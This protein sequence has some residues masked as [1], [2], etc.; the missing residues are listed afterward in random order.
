MA[1]KA[2]GGR[3][4]FVSPGGMPNLSGFQSSA[5]LFSDL[6]KAAYDIGLDE[7]KR[8]YNDLIRQAEIDGKTAGVVYDENNNLVPLTNFDYGEASKTFSPADQRNIL[9]AYKKAALRSYVSAAGSDAVDAAADALRESP[10]DPDKIRGSLAGQLSGLEELDPE[11]YAALAPKVTEAFAVAE[12]KAL[13]QQQLEAKEYAVATN[14]KA[15]SENANKLGV[16]AAKGDGG[17]EL[18]RSRIQANVDEIIEEQEQIFDALRTSG[19]YSEA[20]ILGLKDVQA[21]V[22]TAKAAVAQV[23]RSFAANGVSETYKLVNQIIVDAEADQDVD[24]SKVKALL[25][26]TM[27]GLIAIKN[28]ESD[29]E[30]Q[31]RSGVYN[32]LYKRIIVDGYDILQEFGNPDSDIHSLEG[33]QQATLMSVGS[34]SNSQNADAIKSGYKQQ[35]E[36]HLAVLGAPEQFDFSTTSE[37]MRKIEMLAAFRHIELKD[38]IKAK[39]EFNKAL[40]EFGSGDVQ[41]AGSVL[42][43]ELS[44]SSSFSNPPSYYQNEMFMSSLEDQGVIGKGG[45]YSTRKEYLNEVESYASKWSSRDDDMK[46]AMSAEQ[47][48]RNRIPA[49]QKEMSALKS[50]MGFDKVILS[51]G[52]LADFD[53][54]SQDE[55]IFT[56]SVDAVSA[57]EISTK[58][59]LHPDAKPIFDSAAMTPE[60]ADRAM[61]IMGQTMS[62]IRSANPAMDSWQH[63]GLFYSNFDEDT[64]G[65]LRIADR[66]GIENAL[67]AAS[68]ERSLNR[69]GS[70]VISE[71]YGDDLDGFFDSTWRE[72]LVSDKFFQFL[73]P[74]ISDED[75][76][77]LYAMANQAG[78]GDVEDMF[79]RD[80]YIREALKNKFMGKLMRFPQM[81]PKAAMYDTLREVG[82]RVGPEIDAFSGDLQFV[83]DPILKYAQSTVPGLTMADGSVKYD[84]SL[85]KEDIDSDIKD[86]YLNIPSIGNPFLQK[87]MASVGSGVL[88]DGRLPTPTLHYM[89]NE[90]YGGRP[91][92]TVVL[93]DSYGRAHVINEAYSYDFR[94]TAAFG[95]GL[96]TSSYTEALS[97]LNTD[98][99]KQFWSARGLMDQSLLNSTFRALERNRNDRSIGVLINAYNKVTGLI[100]GQPMSEDPL[101]KEEVDDFFYMIDRVTTLGWR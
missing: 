33:T 18:N 36:N 53:L 68:S 57:F 88:V 89:A 44:D 96:A 60:N 86:K 34:A 51:N 77:M 20:Q 66:V 15:F 22:I 56:R 76:Q 91:S 69:G 92:Y 62:A 94:Q 41:K 70:A 29:E 13:A 6:S 59:M 100:G 101:T 2:T 47:K 93:K 7:R 48:L 24:S 8:E 73:T 38:L 17:S 23:E 85:T 50:V 65:F 82:T 26:S 5:R 4:V 98:R 58:G 61:R 97:Q 40:I 27:S 78:V 11:I 63:E 45:Y 79:L 46:L 42:Q 64:V 14:M 72:T 31:F 55:E 39:E 80:P 9:S 19:E 12:N 3:K 32:D 21:T 75:N 37:A 52:T 10:N 25:N 43:M 67:K 74:A 71:K 35:F 49:S 87:Q 28:A 54:L 83:T 81:D 16:L 84:L 99:A 95:D 30:S 1:F 90:N